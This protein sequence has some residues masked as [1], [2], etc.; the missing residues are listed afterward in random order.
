MNPKVF[1]CI[2]DTAHN[3]DP[4]LTE[5]NILDVLSASHMYE[6]RILMDEC[7]TFLNT[8]I[9]SQNVISVYN[10]LMERDLLA[11]VK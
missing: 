6:I 10:C 4:V 7:L 1:E 2:L 9:K 11:K 8:H 3:F 5:M